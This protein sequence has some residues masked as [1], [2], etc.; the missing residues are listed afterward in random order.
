MKTE[1]LQTKSCDFVYQMGCLK[2]GYCLLVR[3][4]DQPSLALWKEPNLE[5]FL[6]TTPKITVTYI[7]EISAQ[8]CRGRC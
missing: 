2:Q 1:V 5:I 7:N 6:L 8:V 4:F 3:I